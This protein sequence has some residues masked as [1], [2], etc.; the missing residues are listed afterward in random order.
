MF[1]HIPV[2]IALAVVT[3]F[4]TRKGALKGSHALACGSLGFFLSDTSLSGSI[5]SAGAN[6]LSMLGQFAL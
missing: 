2:V 6:L 1:L 4:L 5:H 3:F